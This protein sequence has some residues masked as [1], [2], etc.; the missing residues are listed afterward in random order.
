MQ[1]QD[2]V[3]SIGGFLILMSLIPTLRGE[4]KPALTTGVM[5]FV[6]VAIFACTMA[7]LGLWF[8][9]FANALIS[10][11]WGTLALQR[12]QA[13]QREKAHHLTVAGAIVADAALEEEPF[14]E[15]LIA[16]TVEH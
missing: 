6:L 12:Y 2:W 10:I 9:A 15:P 7:T 8:S 4:Q 11:C 5:S 16:S 3:F 13:D 14:M 1:W